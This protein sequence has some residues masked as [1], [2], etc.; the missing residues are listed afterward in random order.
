MDPAVRALLTTIRD[1]LEAKVEPSRV[2]G[3]LDYTLDPENHI[4]DSDIPKIATDLLREQVEQ[5][6]QQVAEEGP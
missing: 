3:V 5:A 4:P 6:R 1:A 2:F